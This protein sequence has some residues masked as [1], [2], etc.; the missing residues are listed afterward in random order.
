MTKVATDTGIYYHGH[1]HQQHYDRK[2][3]QIIETYVVDDSITRQQHLTLFDRRNSLLRRSNPFA[4][5]ADLKQ[6]SSR[7]KRIKLDPDSP[8]FERNSK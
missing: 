1:T 5:P 6:E 8:R 2:T 7:T 3:D 4:M